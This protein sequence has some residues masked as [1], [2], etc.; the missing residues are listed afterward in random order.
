MDKI[1]KQWRLCG[2]MVDCTYN[3]KAT[4]DG[5]IRINGNW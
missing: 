4:P 2:V 5:K 3:E 1:T